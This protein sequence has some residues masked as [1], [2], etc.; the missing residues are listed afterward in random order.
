MPATKWA[1]FDILAWCAAY[2]TSRQWPPLS[3]FFFA[4]LARNSTFKNDLIRP[5]QMTS[6]FLNI[7]LLQNR[8]R[9]TIYLQIFLNIKISNNWILTRRLNTA[10]KIIYYVDQQ[11]IRKKGENHKISE[12]NQRGKDNQKKGRRTKYMYV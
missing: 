7:I 5:C 8:L 11:D 4:N 1:N 2:E 12:Q 9:L 10:N 6:F 3:G